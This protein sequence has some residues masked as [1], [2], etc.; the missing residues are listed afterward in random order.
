MGATNTKTIDTYNQAVATY[1]ER[2]PMTV[3]GYLQ[4]W[5][6]ACFVDIPLDAPIL[7]VGSASGRDAE[8]LEN[9]LGLTDVVRSD[10]SP[11]FVSHL[12]DSG[13]EAAQ[14]DLLV[15][16]IPAGAFNVIFANAVMLHF[17]NDELP[18]AL[19]NIHQGLKNNGEFF[20]TTKR[21]DSGKPDAGW[22]N[23][24]LGTGRY[25]SRLDEATLLQQLEATGFAANDTVV[26]T[27]PSGKWY[28]VATRKVAA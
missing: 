24:K 16:A 18:I 27:D 20:F 19:A 7:E 11:S 17:D 1:I 4:Q 15:D 28:H 9:T 14:L 23:Q 6:D 26:L 21:P 12:R 2:S 5:I 10:G 8:Y 22:S 13:T 25:F 3:E